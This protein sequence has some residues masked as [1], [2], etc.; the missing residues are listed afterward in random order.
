M[1][2]MFRRFT[3]SRAGIII[4]FLVL[5]AIALAFA[6]A[7]V[8]D[9]T[10]GG[11]VASGDIAEVGGEGI[12]ANELRQ[13]A[14]SE[15][16]AARR[17][18]PSFDIAQ[19]LGAG[20]LDQAV[21]RLVNGQA[22]WRFGETQ[23]VVVS[24]RSIDGEIASIPAFLGPTGQFDPNLYQSL[25]TQRRLTDAEVRKDF[26]Q[27]LMAQRLTAPQVGASQVPALLA[28]PYASLLLERRAGQIGFIPAS[29][30]P[31]GAAPTP[32][33]LQTFYGRNLA[34]YTVPER[35]TVRY[36]L[37]TPASVGA[38]AQ[39][40]DAEIAAAYRRDRARYAPSERRTI[41]QVVAAD[42]GGANALAARVRAGA[43]VADAARA[44]G[45][46]A[47]T[48][49]AVDRAAYAATAGEAAATAAFA[50]TKGT[51]IGP[52]RGPIGFV[53]ARVEDVT[54]SA[55]RTLAQVR[56]EIVAALTRRKTAEALSEAQGA[57]DEALTG[58]A[59][60]DEVV[61]DRKLQARSTRPLLASGADPENP[62]ARPDPALAP[63]LQAAFA[64]EPGD[65]PQL[66]PIGTDGG[67]A[68]VALGNVVPAAPRPLAA[69]GDQVG[70]D[71]IADRRRQAARRIAAQVVAQAGKGTPLPRALDATGLRLPAPRP[72]DIARSQIAANPRGTEPAL[73]LLFSMA[74][75]TAKLL[76]P[77]GRDGWLVIKLDRVQPGDARGNQGLIN[78][79]RADLGRVVGR[80]YAEQFVRAARNAVGVEV[81]RDAVARVRAELQ[82]QAR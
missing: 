5:G 72:L 1:L 46:E 12:T 13:A 15:V 50:A 2:Q 68:L 71:L 47:T 35:R 62:A 53:V 31:A 36:A 26:A 57:I 4:S 78:A 34:R 29:S 79:T 74:P 75:G 43:S 14:E 33:E 56:P 18:Q 25:L 51:L 63:I 32:A 37:V 42:Q 60:F 38:Q 61:A 7:D 45:L 23:D 65:A 44:A 59:T 80:E 9:L 67:F 20:G 82:G 22:L 28:L 58:N 52:V 11:A 77:P 49:A 76:E 40:T 19:Y 24:K 27:E 3:K 73:A 66:V 8:G 16:E 41:A 55:G 70:R 64:V 48:R 21:E 10:P 17:S 6:A 54:L 69:I 39:P 30:V 81:D